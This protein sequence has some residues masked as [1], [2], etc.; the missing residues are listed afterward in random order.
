MKIKVHKVSSPPRID[1]DLQ[2]DSLHFFALD[3]P[4][5]TVEL[6]S[7]VGFDRVLGFKKVHPGAGEIVIV[8]NREQ[9]I[10]GEA[11]LTLTYQFET[12]VLASADENGWLVATGFPGT[13]EGV[14]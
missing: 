11:S 1:H 9:A 10:D 4:S 12:A 2:G 13:S 7:S 6:P 14:N 3:F 5:G 8:P